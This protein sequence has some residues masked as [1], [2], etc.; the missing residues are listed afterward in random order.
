MRNSFSL[1]LLEQEANLLLLQDT[2]LLCLL[3]PPTGFNLFRIKQNSC[4]FSASWKTGDGAGSISSEDGQTLAEE[5]WEEQQ[6]HEALPKWFSED[7]TFSLKFFVQEEPSATLQWFQIP[8]EHTPLRGPSVEKGMKSKFF[9]QPV[10]NL[11]TRRGCSGP[12]EVSLQGQRLRFDSSRAP[13]N[14]ADLTR[15]LFQSKL[16][17]VALRQTAEQAVFLRALEHWSSSG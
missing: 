5:C 6:R 3:L 2:N 10:T 7:K 11:S 12:A 4:F 14:T 15:L 9:S 17:C 1:C 8:D 13:F 16:C